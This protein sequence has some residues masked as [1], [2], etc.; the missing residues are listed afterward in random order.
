MIM[1]PSMFLSG[2]ALTMLTIA[3]PVAPAQAAIK[4]K[5]KKVAAKTITRSWV[6]LKATTD[7]KRYTSGQPI[8][9]RLTATNNAKRGAYLYFSSGQR[10]DFTVFP[11]GKSESVYTWSAARMFAQV[12]GSLWLKPGQSQSFE[13][14]VGEEMGTLKPGKYVLRARLSNSPRPIVAAPVEFEIAGLGLSMTARTDKTIYKIGEPVQVSATAT[15]DTG[16][17]NRVTFNSGLD[18]DVFITDEAGNPIWNYGANLRFIRALGEVT[19]QK[20]EAKNY[21]IT[22]NGEVLPADSTPTTLKP[23]R[24]RVQA[25]LQSTP[26][27]YAAPITIEITP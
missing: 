2:V 20:G 25:V 26:Q 3:G 27:L 16:K 10:F 17:A 19:W 1:K 13:A 18:C 5:T 24:Y 11:K 4:A 8:P 7:Q 6:T 23:G 21:S 22:W 15:N 14:N 12:T 9:V